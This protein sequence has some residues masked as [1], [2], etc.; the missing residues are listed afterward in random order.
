MRAFPLGF[1]LQEL[2]GLERNPYDRI[3]HLMQGFV[4]VMI[5]REV[6]FRGGYVTRPANARVRLR[7][8]SRWRSA[9][10]TS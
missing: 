1:A 10:S 2:L 3:G 5:A 4:P 8:P 9:R 7:C 6:L